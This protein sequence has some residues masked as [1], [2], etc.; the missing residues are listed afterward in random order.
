MT[1][2]TPTPGRR[3]LT[4]QQWHE[5]IRAR[6]RQLPG[7]GRDVLPPNMGEKPDDLDELRRRVQTPRGAADGLNEPGSAVPVRFNTDQSI[8]EV[9]QMTVQT[10]PAS[11]PPAA[12]PARWR[13]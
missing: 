9:Q 7:E 13:G 10:I 6:A 3:P 2:P 1:E 5:Q 8:A 12:P 11:P 4:E